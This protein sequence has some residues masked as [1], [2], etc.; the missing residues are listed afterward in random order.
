M[1]LQTP[2]GNL[3]GRLCG[4]GF[5]GV[6]LDNG[7]RVGSG[8]C[9]DGRCHRQE[10]IISLVRL[11]CRS[12]CNFSF[13]PLLWLRGVLRRVWGILRLGGVN[14]RVL[15]DALALVFDR[16][17]CFIEAFGIFLR[18]CVLNRT[19]THG[20]VT[21]VETIVGKATPHENQNITQ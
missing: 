6:G 10:T 4:A 17:K 2:P 16:I 21:K 5:S 19:S 9:V 20:L 3:G 18:G 7:V 15:R 12:E 11:L 8:V 14:W 13:C 1:K